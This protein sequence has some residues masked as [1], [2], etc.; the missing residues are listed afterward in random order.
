MIPKPGRGCSEQVMRRQ[1]NRDRD[2]G[3]AGWI[4]V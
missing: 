2:P 3:T 1:E 4:E